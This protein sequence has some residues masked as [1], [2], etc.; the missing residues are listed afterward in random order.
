[1]QK[2][3]SDAFAKSGKSAAARIEFDAPSGRL[4]VRAGADVH[5]VLSGQ[6]VESPQ[7]LA[8]RD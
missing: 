7:P 8:K 3:I 2:Q 6:L 1:V 4:I 5:R